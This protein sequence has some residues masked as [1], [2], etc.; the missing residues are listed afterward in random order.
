[1]ERRLVVAILLMIAVAVVPSLFLKPA[2]RPRP[3]RADTAQAPAA[4]PET[5]RTG[6]APQEA[7]VRQRPPVATAAKAETVVVATPAAQYR[8]S[9]VGAALVGAEMSAYRSYAGASRGEPADLLRAAPPMLGQRLVVGRD[10]IALDGVS[11]AAE[12]TAEG[13]AFR[14]RTDQLDL[15]VAVAPRPGQEYLLD[16]SGQVDGLGGQ[17][18]LLLISLGSGFANVEADSVSN[19]RSY[20]IVGRQAAPVSV[21]F[22]KLKPGETTTLDGPFDWVA[23]KSK[24][25]IGALLSPDSTHPS[26]G[27]AIA[28]GE[29]RTSRYA[30][31]A[32]G[33]ATLPVGPDGRFRYSLYLGPQEYRQLRRLGRGLDKASPYGWIFKPIVMPVSVWITEVLLWL[34]QRLSLAYGWV[35]I[36]FGIAIRLVLWPLNQKAMMS[37]V[38]MQAVQ[39][40]LKDIQTRYKDDPQRLQQE[41]MKLYREHK[42]NP[43]GSC[44]PMLI[45]FPILLALFFVFANTIAFR[46]ASFLWLPDLSLRDPTYVIPVVMGASMWAL[47]KLGQMGMPPN[48]QAKMMTTIMPIMMTVL[49]LNFASGL[50]LYYA[51][52]NLVSLPQQYL[53]NKAR[54]REMARR[55]GSA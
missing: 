55:K 32:E 36:L 17:G 35:L 44:L 22:G 8:L 7:P 18:A 19:Y 39:P 42:V 16:V 43:F 2:P 21:A 4:A 23:V 51:V 28:T 14:G 48:P 13:A 40:L 50:N 3:V 24:Y 11:Y 52:S 41:M 10:T 12:R 1:M 49:F 46:G 26:F 47:S 34:H 33:W 45:P 53:I 5:A 29:P 9:S 30:V 6:A 15:L 31:S 25:F 27:G 54:V 20:G 38:A 37:S